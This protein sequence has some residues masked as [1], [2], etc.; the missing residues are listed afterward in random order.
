[1][2]TISNIFRLYGCQTIFSYSDTIAGLET[3][4]EY[5]N[6]RKIVLVVDTWN[7]N[8]MY[9]RFEYTLV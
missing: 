4:I 5:N 3:M 6:I 9:V 1:M 7:T 8:E 2:M